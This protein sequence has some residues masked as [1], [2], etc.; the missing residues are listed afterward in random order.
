ML[1]ILKVYVAYFLG[2]NSLKQIF[3]LSGYLF[4]LCKDMTFPLIT[5]FNS[6]GSQSYMQIKSN[7]DLILYSTD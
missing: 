1:P 3:I 4:T 7:S 2:L 5:R 6:N